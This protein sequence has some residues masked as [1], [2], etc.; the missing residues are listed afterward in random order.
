[1]SLRQPPARLC[2]MISRNMARSASSFNARGGYLVV[3]VAKTSGY[4]S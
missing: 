3:P 4:S 2:A 1:M